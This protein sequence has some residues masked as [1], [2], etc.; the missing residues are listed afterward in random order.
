MPALLHVEMG[1]ALGQRH[2][3]GVAGRTVPLRREVDDRVRDHAIDAVV[4]DH[5]AQAG[6]VLE[7]LHDGRA[8]SV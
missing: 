6:N 8:H 5:R 1:L 4:L 7:R 3:D 2:L